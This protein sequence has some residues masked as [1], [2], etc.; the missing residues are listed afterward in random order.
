MQDGMSWDAL[1]NMSEYMDEC[2]AKFGDNALAK[3][4]F[5]ARYLHLTPGDLANVIKCLW[6]GRH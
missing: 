1:T 6:T 4:C 3:G 5:I 2:E